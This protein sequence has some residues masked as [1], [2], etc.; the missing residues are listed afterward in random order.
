MLKQFVFGS[1]LQL[2]VVRLESSPVCQLQRSHSF[3]PAPENEVVREVGLQEVG[4]EL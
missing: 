4:V 3:G 2:K 1:L